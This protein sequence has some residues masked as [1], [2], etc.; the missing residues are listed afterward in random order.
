MEKGIAWVK[1]E[2]SFLAIER[3]K[4]KYKLPAGPRAHL[5]TKYEHNLSSV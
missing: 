5:C 4:L 2:G 3:K 1:R